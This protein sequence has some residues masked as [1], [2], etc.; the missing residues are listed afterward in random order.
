[1]LARTFQPRIGQ[2][3]KHTLGSC[4]GPQGSP[5]RQAPDQRQPEPDPRLLTLEFLCTLKITDTGVEFRFF[6]KEFP[7]S[8]KELIFLLGFHARCSV[9]LDLTLP[10]F[11]RGQF[12]QEITGKREFNY[13]RTN[14]INN[15]TLRFMHRWLGMTMCS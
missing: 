3:P 11:E 7:P 14:D 10:G 8:W 15:L 12:W 13:S 4:S 9:D 6:G 5:E 1:V 2:K